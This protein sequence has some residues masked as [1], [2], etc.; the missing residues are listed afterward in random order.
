MNAYHRSQQFLED[1]RKAA[2]ATGYDP[3]KLTLATNGKNKLTYDSPEGIKHFGLLGYGDFN[4]YKRFDP[5]IAEQ[6]RRI[7]RA[8]HGEI[9]RI[10]RLNR[11]SPNELA[12][13][14][15]W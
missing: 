14:I 10:H 2:K 1:A 4:Y 8:S 7:F 15:L 13:N 11:F 5:G 9:S 12:I 3:D 6:K